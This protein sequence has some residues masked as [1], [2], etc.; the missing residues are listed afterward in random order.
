MW[1]ARTPAFPWPAAYPT[2]TTLYNPNEAEAGYTLFIPLGRSSTPTAF[3]INMSGQIVHYW[4]LPPMFAV[5]ARLLPNGNLLF[6]GLKNDKSNGRAGVGKLWMGGAADTIMEVDWNGKILFVHED[7]S[8][9]HDFVKLSNGH[10]LFLG[11]ERVPKALRQ[12][13]KGGIRGTEFPEGVMFNDYLMEVD[14]YGRKVWAWHANDHLDPDIDIIGPIYKREE[15]LHCSCIAEL[16]NGNILLTSRDTDSIFVINKRSG[17]I[18]YRWGNNAHLDKHTQTIEYRLGPDVLGG[19]HGG[20]EIPQGYPGAGN[21]L[22]YDNA[23]YSFQSRAVEFNIASRKVVWTSGQ[24][25]FGRVN[26]S[27]FLG[28]AQ[29]LRSGNTLICEGAN[30]VISQETSDKKVVWQYVNPYR[31][32]VMN[33]AILKAYFYEPEYCRQFRG[34]E[35]AAGR[36]IVPPASESFLLPANDHVRVPEKEGQPDR[37]PLVPYLIAVIA[38]LVLV[39][40]FTR[41]RR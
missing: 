40:I 33:G 30:G 9:H 26:F 5:S 14:Q 2:G 35:A 20:N 1:F 28:N 34:L 27:W 16:A 13:V 25:N 6:I 36:A 11:W 21:I 29:R 4:Q 12:K 32:P 41:T 24:S 15:W 10:Y 7:S 17:K 22:C 8:L 3:L 37:S 18:T 39:L 31:T 19:P 23:L 38:G